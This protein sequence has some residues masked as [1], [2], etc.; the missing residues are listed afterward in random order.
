ML[1]QGFHSVREIRKVREFIR[2]SGIVREEYFVNLEKFINKY[3]LFF[4]DN[5]IYI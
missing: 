2:G 4:L 1:V 5:S 3:N